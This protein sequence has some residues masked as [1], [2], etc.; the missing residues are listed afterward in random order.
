MVKETDRPE[1][2]NYGRHMFNMGFI[3]GWKKNGHAR[4]RRIL[5]KEKSQQRRFGEFFD[6]IEDLCFGNRRK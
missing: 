1:V 2:R 6:Y 4:R 5:L 3:Q